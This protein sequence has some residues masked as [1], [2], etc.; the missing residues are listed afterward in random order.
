MHKQHF[1]INVN[2][3]LNLKGRCLL[4]WLLVIITFLTFN[5]NG[6]A[7]VNIKDSLW[8]ISQTNSLPDT[9]RIQAVNSLIKGEYFHDQI[10]S[11][12]TLANLQQQL[13]EHLKS[14]DHIANAL[15]TK[16]YCYECN[17]KPDLALS[18]YL[19][20][21]TSSK[22]IQDTLAIINTYEKI[23][24]IYEEC[25]KLNLVISY[26]N[27][28]QMLEAQI[29]AH[30]SRINT[31][32][33][34]LDIY[35]IQGNYKKA[36]KLGTKTLSIAEKINHN[37]S[38]IRTLSGIGGLHLDLNNS[39]KAL[40]YSKK[41]VSLVIPSTDDVSKIGAF[42][43]LA[44]VYL[45]L[46]KPEKAIVNLHEVVTIASKLDA[47]QPLSMVYSNLGL[48]YMKIDELDKA[49]HYFNKSFCLAQKTSDK[50]TA[51]AAYCNLGLT[52]SLLNLHDKAIKFGALSLQLSEESGSL[53]SIKQNSECL[54]ISYKKAKKFEKALA[55]YEKYIAVSDSIINLENQSALAEQEIQYNYDKKRF[56]DSITYA[57]QQQL[58]L[59][60][61]DAA[62]AEEEKNRYLLYFVSLLSML[63]A[64]IGCRAYCRKRSMNKKLRWQNDNK[65]AIIKEIH[66]R[67][68]NNLQVINGL[69]LL[70]SREIKDE[71][72][73]E[74]FKEAQNRVLSMALLHEKMYLTDDLQNIDIKEHITFLVNDLVKNNVIDK[75]I[76]TNLKIENINIGIKTLVPLGLIIN[77]V[78]TN[79]VKYAFTNQD[80]GIIMVHLEQVNN[81]TYKMLI[82][83]NGN[84]TNTLKNST[85]MGTL[86]IENFTKQLEGS[87]SILNQPGTVYEIFFKSVDHY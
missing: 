15:N 31:Y 28:K 54:Y 77:E 51:A 52:Y 17:N 73:I 35:R 8:K 13:G 23:A 56:Q 48:A 11:L 46:E 65:S 69:L 7:Q 42:N 29:G 62:K 32:L 53:Y 71:K 64:F 37:T 1:S 67:V 76:T 12:L 66:H 20:S 57:Q 22:R 49:I 14:Y 78:I 83:D 59:L 55:I 81:K 70:Q 6:I 16:G 41:A 72:V 36:I 63:L 39:S 50:K 74:S 9:T 86:L 79:A 84:G 85:G 25:G 68:K 58:N 82:G 19:K 34:L 5:N 4:N 40:F 47:P 75:D 26:L 18:C 45:F 24:D 38:I 44:S 2:G 80:K 33:L 61:L 43:N 21:V 27:K 30:V 3:F 10:D 87:I 60:K